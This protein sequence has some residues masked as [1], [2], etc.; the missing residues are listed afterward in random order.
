MALAQVTLRLGRLVAKQQ[1]RQPELKNDG[2]KKQQHDK[3]CRPRH[4]W[5]CDF[6]SRPTNCIA[7]LRAGGATRP[8]KGDRWSK[9]SENKHWHCHRGGGERTCTDKGFAV[10]KPDKQQT[11]KENQQTHGNMLNIQCEMAN[12]QEPTG[13]WERNSAPIQLHREKGRGMDGRRTVDGGRQGRTEGRLEEGQKE[14]RQREHDE[15][16]RQGQYIKH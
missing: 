8:I 14:G 4:P 11:R 15:G 6:G 9:P 5:T 2:R 7:A 13:I 3:E 16:R 1:G 12:T 10:S